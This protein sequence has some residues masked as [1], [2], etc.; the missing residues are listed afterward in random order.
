M[1]F[2]LKKISELNEENSIS[3][4]IVDSLAKIL[5]PNPLVSTTVPNLL[6]S[7]NPLKSISRNK[8]RNK[9]VYPVR[10]SVF[11]CELFNG[12]AEHTGIYIGNGKIVELNGNGKIRRVSFNKFLNSGVNRTG[13]RIY[14]ACDEYNEPLNFESTAENAESMVG[15]K[16]FYNIIMDNCHQFTSGCITGNF[17]NADNFFFMLEHTIKHEMNFGEI[18]KWNRVN[19]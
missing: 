14:T 4:S 15:E 7:S 5:A 19:Y 9:K 10:G 2:L 3:G 1:S 18:I 16:R 17:E 11:V 6:K 8:F 13:K 12:M